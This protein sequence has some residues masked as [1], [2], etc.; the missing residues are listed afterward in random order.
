MIFM[1]I[2]HIRALGYLF[3]QLMNINYHKKIE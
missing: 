1:N 2:E 3:F